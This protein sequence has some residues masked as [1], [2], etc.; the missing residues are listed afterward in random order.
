MLSKIEQK[1]KSVLLKHTEFSK[2]KEK[3]S[4]MN[5]DLAIGFIEIFYHRQAMQYI[6]CTFMT[7]ILRFE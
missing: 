1:S 5:P 4:C 2:L 7:I 3:A 6:E